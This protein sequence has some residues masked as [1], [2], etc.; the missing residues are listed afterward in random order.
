[1][2]DVEASGPAGQAGL[3]PGDLLLGLDGQ[4]LA[5]ASEALAA[6][7]AAEPFQ[8]MAF[9]IERGSRR[10]AV[11]LRLGSSPWVPGGDGP[12]APDPILWAAANSRL[13]SPDSELPA[14]ALEF[15]RGL[16]LLRSGEPESAVNLL[17]SIRVTGD[18]PFGQAAADYWL[19]LALLAQERPDDA[20]AAAAFARAMERAG[21]RLEHNDGPHVA[22]RAAVRRA[23]IE[24]GDPG[25]EHEG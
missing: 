7:E 19:G 12:Q 21:A 5:T 15:H 3:R 17:G 18:S 4:A 8:A 22:P 9:D 23:R 14:W 20:G 25:G 10:L 16:A 6:V 13:V 11:P 24:A 1:M 2:L